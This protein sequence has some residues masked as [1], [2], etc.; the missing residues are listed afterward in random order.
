M[1]A[2]YG[3]SLTPTGTDWELYMLAGDN[4]R[5]IYSAEIQF[6]CYSDDGERSYTA[7]KTYS[8]PEANFLW[9]LEKEELARELGIMAIRSFLR[10]D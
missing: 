8:L 2:V 3:E 6:M 5:D 4:C 10:R 7:E 1:A 9:M